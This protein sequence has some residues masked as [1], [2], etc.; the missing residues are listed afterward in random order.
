MEITR[1]SGLNIKEVY[2]DKAYFRKPILDKIIGMAAKPYIS[3]SKTVYRIDEK[4]FSYSKDS[5][6]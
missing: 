3:V 1:K 2:R 6:E 4:R 5:D